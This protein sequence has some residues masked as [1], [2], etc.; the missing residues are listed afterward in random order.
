MRARNY[1][2]ILGAIASILLA[3]AMSLSG[4]VQI[5]VS[6]VAAVLGTVAVILWFHADAIDRRVAD[7]R[8]RRGLARLDRMGGGR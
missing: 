8:I 7:R 1:A 3:A 6:A 5:L 4:R 2:R